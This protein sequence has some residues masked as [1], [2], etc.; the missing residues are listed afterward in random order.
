MVVDEA[1]RSLHDAM[2]VTRNLIRDNRI[3]YGGGSAEISCALKVAEYANSISGMEQYAIRA[4]AQALEVIP[5]ALAENSGLEPIESVSEAKRQQI[6][7]GKPFLVLSRLLVCF[8]FC[9]VS[10]ALRLVPST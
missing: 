7:T 10:T 5:V 6:A 2:C 8:S 3:V 4:F 1:E 9:R